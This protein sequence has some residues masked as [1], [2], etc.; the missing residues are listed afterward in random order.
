MNRQLRRLAIARLAL[1]LALV[2]PAAV[3]AEESPF[4]QSGWYGVVTPAPGASNY[5]GRFDAAYGSGYGGSYSTHSGGRGG[6]DGLLVAAKIF[7]PLLLVMLPVMAVVLVVKG[8]ESSASN[9]S[10][11]LAPLPHQA[12]SASQESTRE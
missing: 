11:E 6:P 10:M 7:P 12:D 2:G 3:H 5:S 9:G 4:P 8:I 1:S